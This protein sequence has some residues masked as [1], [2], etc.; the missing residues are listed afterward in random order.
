[1]EMAEKLGKSPSFLSAIEHGHKQAP[2]GFESVI[3]EAYQLKEDEA[4]RII[5]AAS[6]SKE[7]FHLAPSSPFARD[8][9]GL[10]ARKFDTLSKA[11]LKE[12]QDILKGKGDKS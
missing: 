11:Q 8:T 6:R 12:I 1:M 5:R 9:A 7:R 2:S 3:I 4:A 10:L